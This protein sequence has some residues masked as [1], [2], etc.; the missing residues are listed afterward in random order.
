MSAGTVAVATMAVDLFEAAQNYLEARDELT[1]REDAHSE[2]IHAGELQPGD[3]DVAEIALTA[4]E[5]REALA[6][7]RLRA[8]VA[9]W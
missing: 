8:K 6:L 3:L 2:L 9:A 4:A 1:A 7:A 5:E